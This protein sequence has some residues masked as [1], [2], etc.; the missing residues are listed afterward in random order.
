MS[1]ESSGSA[2]CAGPIGPPQAFISAAHVAATKYARIVVVP[3]FRSA[4]T[5]ELC[6][7]TQ[8]ETLYRGQWK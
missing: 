3:T 6:R 4:L 5:R 7:I 1:R 8:W 2:T